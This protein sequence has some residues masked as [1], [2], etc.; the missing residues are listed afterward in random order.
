MLRRAVFWLL[1]L[2][3]T[4]GP[5][6]AVQ[7]QSDAEPLQV[8]STF[9]IL[10]DLVRHVG[11]DA[12]VAHT[13]VGAGGDSH[14][15]EPAPADVALVAEADLV[16]AI[17]L[18]FEPWLGDLVASSG[19]EA[20][21]VL[22]SDRVPLLSFETDHEHEEETHAE[23]EEAAEGDEEHAHG[24]FD[25]HI[26]HDVS[27]AVI[28]VETIRDALVAADPANAATYEANAAAYIAELEALDGWVMEQVA[29]LPEDQRKLVTSHESL[30]Y[31]AHRYGFELVGTAF[32]TLSTE[33]GDPSAAEIARLVAEIETQ[34][35]KAIFAENTSNP[36]LMAAIAAEAGVTLAPT[37]YTDALGEPGSGAETYLDLIRANTNEIVTA[38]S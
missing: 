20:A 24:E 12:V 30:G 10:D 37:L 6:A 7:A 27:N 4:S 13:L 3:F 18:E 34:G 21:E 38:L 9:S 19:T 16:F 11:G 5:E 29:T 17:G 28:M 23:S 36:D 22:V 1:I 31:Y 35:V 32:G 8:V 15:Y 14:T 2:V 33:A 25:P 26:W